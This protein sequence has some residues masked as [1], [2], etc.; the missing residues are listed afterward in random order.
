MQ[1]TRYELYFT[2]KNQC[3]LL[4]V[5]YSFFLSDSIPYNCLAETEY[6]R[7]TIATTPKK[8]ASSNQVDD[9]NTR[10]VSNASPITPIIAITKHKNCGGGEN[11]TKEKKVITCLLSFEDILNWEVL[12]QG[13]YQYLSKESLFFQMFCFQKLFLVAA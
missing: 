9:S 6:I 3:F 12:L 10:V 8:T 7:G 1:G 2:G 11:A 4:Q 13:V 5:H